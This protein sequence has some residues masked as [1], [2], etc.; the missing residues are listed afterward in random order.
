[1]LNRR[2]GKTMEQTEHRRRKRAKENNPKKIIYAMNVFIV[3]WF[4][5][6]R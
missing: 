2:F 5:L 6:I 4:S 1:M 3:L